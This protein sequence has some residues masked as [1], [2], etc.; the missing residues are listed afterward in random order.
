MDPDPLRH[1]EYFSVP[2]NQVWAPPPVALASCRGRIWFALLLTPLRQSTQSISPL[3]WEQHR[4]Q[5]NR[6][7]HYG[8]PPWG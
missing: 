7:R 3:A 2:N 6:R 8:T 1:L 4:P 5:P